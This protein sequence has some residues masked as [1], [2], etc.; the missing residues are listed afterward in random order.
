[1]ILEG[2]VTTLDEDGRL[3]VAPMGPRMLPDGRR[4]VLRPYR[5]ATTYRNLKATGEGVLHVHDD[6]V[7][8]ARAAI[9]R[10]EDAE[11]LPASVVRGRVLAGCCRYAEFRVERLDDREDRTTIEAVVVASGRFR[12]PFGWNRG[13]FAV[14]EA[15]ILATRVELLDLGRM[16][17]QFAELAVLVD[18]TGGP[19]E[20]EAFGL[21]DRYVREAARARGI[22]PEAPDA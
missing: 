22:D 10:V 7:L 19:A 9:E 11:T 18:K 12:D 6:P 8:L 13:Q 3:N 2:I 1:V 17:A 14:L 20:H 5:T 4:F 21:L 15:A 16:L